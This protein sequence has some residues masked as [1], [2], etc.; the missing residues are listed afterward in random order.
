MIR[1]I[2]V[3]RPDRIQ[4]LMTSFP[5]QQSETDIEPGFPGKNEDTHHKRNMDVWFLPAG[6]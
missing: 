1:K 5:G 4:L 6:H 2:S 3:V